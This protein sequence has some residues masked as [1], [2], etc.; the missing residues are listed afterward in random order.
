MASIIAQ[1]IHPDS[2]ALVYT[3]VRK[4]MLELQT[5]ESY[6]K[7]AT[8]QNN[9]NLVR[10]DLFDASKG[11]IVDAEDNKICGMILPLYQGEF[12]SL[13]DNRF[14]LSVKELQD[15]EIQAGIKIDSFP[16]RKNG[17]ILKNGAKRIY[18]IMLRSL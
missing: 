8:A 6:V 17:V 3:L 10:P 15:I 11:L 14:G 5:D 13:Q 2:P 18:D 7:K 9:A 1:V 16:H 12:M 4:L